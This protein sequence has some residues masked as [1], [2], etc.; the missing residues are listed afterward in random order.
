LHDDSRPAMRRCAGWRQLRHT[1]RTGHKESAQLNGRPCS[2][3]FRGWSGG[4][5]K[6]RED[7]PGNR[8][9]VLTQW[10]QPSCSRRVE[11]WRGGPRKLGASPGRRLIGWTG[12]PKDVATLRTAAEEFGVPFVTAARPRNWVRPSWTGLAQAVAPGPPSK[13]SPKRCVAVLSDLQGLIKGPADVVTSSTPIDEGRGNTWRQGH[14]DIPEGCAERR[15]S[16]AY[17]PRTWP[18]TMPERVP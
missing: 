9:S 11:L 10:L 16:K 2:G 6:G 15:S 12:P 5:P 14:A 3:A 17:L 7:A 4:G 13:G 1:L 18:R 8:R